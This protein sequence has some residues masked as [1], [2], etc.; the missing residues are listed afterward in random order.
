ME[1]MELNLK[2]WN[3]QTYADY[4]RYLK[5]LADKDYKD[6]NSKITPNS[7]SEIFGVRVPKMREC[8][9]SISKGCF[10]EF[11]KTADEAAK[12]RNLS[13]EEITI[14]G[15]VIGYTKL[16][17]GE[18]CERIRRYSQLVNNWACCDVPV[19]SFKQV[20]SFKEEY[21][22][23]IYAM[24]KSQNFWQQRVGVIMLLD[25]YLSDTDDA[26]YAL[27]SINKVDSHEYYVMMAQAWLITTAFAKHKDLTKEFMKDT[28]SLSDE[29]RK[30]TV[31]KIRDSFRISADDKEWAKNWK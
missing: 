14:Y 25:H 11:I 2:T 24:L 6:F 16:P 20:R 27:D 18:M 17:F 13:H 8:A 26:A 23:E 28:F 5:S 3:M 15:L 29:V 9:K 7:E 22:I 31:R 12:T 21:K 4:L 1:F 10:R 19:S 30:M